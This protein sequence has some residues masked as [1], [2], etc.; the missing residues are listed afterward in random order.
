MA[1]ELTVVAAPS[2]YERDTANTPIDPGYEAADVANGNE[3]RS[4]GRELVLVRNVDGVAP[5]NVT[6]TSQPASRTGRLG[7]ITATVIPLNGFMVFQIFPRD[8]WESGG[9]IAISGDNVNIEFAIVRLPLQA[10]G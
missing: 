7:H 10:A 3:F 1:T 8:G 6:V 2:A 5:H 9:L 4:T